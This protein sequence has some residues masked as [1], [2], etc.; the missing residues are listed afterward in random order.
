ME[1]KIHQFVTWLIDK[2][3]TDIRTRDLRERSPLTEAMIFV[4]ARSAR[5]AQALADEVM[6]QTAAQKWDY[7]GV[8]GYQH[9]HWILVDCND[10][11]VHIFQQETRDMYNVEM[12]YA[13]APEFVLSP[14]VEKSLEANA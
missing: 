12:L 10:V 9:G 11:I 6:Q 2:K 7:F 14:E 3:G 5:H 13:K 4:T 1:E 8:E